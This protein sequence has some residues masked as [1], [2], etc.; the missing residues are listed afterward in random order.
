MLC[1]LLYSQTELQM[2][3][4]PKGRFVYV[5]KNAFPNQGGTEFLLHFKP[6]ILV[7]NQDNAI[8]G[9]YSHSIGWSDFEELPLRRSF[10]LSYRRYFVNEFRRFPVI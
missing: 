5:N 8:I 7:R 2:G 4:Y 3:L 10:H 1:N 6:G 9:K